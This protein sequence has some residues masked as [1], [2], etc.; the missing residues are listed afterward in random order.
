[1]AWKEVL[2]MEERR[3]F[4]LEVDQGVCTFS[5][6]CEEY[7]ISR[8]TGY[9]WYNRFVEE[10]FEGLEDRGC[11]PKHCPHR[12]DPW[13]EE[14]VVA[15][16]KR[17]SKW[18]PRKLAVELAKKH[19]QVPFPA[20]STIGEV[21]NRR[22]LVK[23]RRRRRGA[24]HKWPGTLT[25][26]QGAN[27]VW[28]TDFKGWFRTGNGRRCDPLTISDLSTRFVIGCDA[29]S[30][31]YEELV[32]PVF[33][34]AFREYGL[35]EVIRV[36][37]G[38]PFG[39]RGA[40][41]LTSLSLWWIQLGIRVEFIDRGHPEQNGIHERMHR[42]LKA[43][44]SCPPERNCRQQQKRFDHWRMEFNYVRPHEA[45]GMRCPGELYEKSQRLYPRRLDDFHYPPHFVVRRVR[46][47][48]QLKWQGR[49]RAIGRAFKNALV[50]LEPIDADHWRV[51]VGDLTLGT[52]TAEGSGPLRP[53]VFAARNPP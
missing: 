38:A 47:N 26:P 30:G 25:K 23:A 3:R 15:E 4:V 32:R 43:E 33:R 13:I 27:H 9:K 10:S 2:P 37:N 34:G 44:T 1:M 12:T 52:L 16:R 18:G 51:H 8:K 22:G 19:P 21:L 11:A 48:G 28:A 50:G 45:L 35:P 31:Q 7:G 20:P 5:E 41:G 39:S 6:L 53:T 49:P 14:L 46:K 42:T 36:D 17:H 40:L 29:L 24:V